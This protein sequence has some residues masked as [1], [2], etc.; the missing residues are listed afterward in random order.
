MIEIQGPTSGQN[1]ADSDPACFPFL[2][3]FLLVLG[4]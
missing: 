3:V 4:V 1:A 2:L